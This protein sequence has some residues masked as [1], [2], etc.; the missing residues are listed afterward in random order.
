MGRQL[1]AAKLT[2]QLHEVNGQPGAVM[3]DPQ[4][5]II[6]VFSLDITDGVVQTIRS[7]INP[8]KLRH[9]GPLADVRALLRDRRER[10]RS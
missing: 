7:V 3:L 4:Q 1:T 6:N 9:L 10:P 8:D 5:R 2:L